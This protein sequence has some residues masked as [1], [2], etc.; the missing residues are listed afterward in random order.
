MLKLPRATPCYPWMPH[1]QYV[2]EFD[3]LEN[4]FRRALHNLADRFI[5]S[6]NFSLFGILPTLQL[7]LALAS[8]SPEKTRQHGCE[9]EHKERNQ[10]CSRG[11]SLLVRVLG[12]QARALTSSTTTHGG[13]HGAFLGRHT[14]RT[15]AV[16]G[17]G[18]N[19]LVAVS[20]ISCGLIG[21]A[22]GAVPGML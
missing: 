4:A 19:H 3:D 22:W 2:T 5:E 7:K 11:A 21:V 20:P 13:D 1:I 17:Q 10:K 16:F 6:S 18:G 8:F 15:D 14:L 12:R 9:K